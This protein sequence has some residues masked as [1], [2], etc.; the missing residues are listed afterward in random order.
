M[1]GMTVG[2]GGCWP[3]DFGP[4][5]PVVGEGVRA[6]GCRGGDGVGRVEGGGAGGAVG[7]AARGAAGG[8]HCMRAK[9]GGGGGWWGEL[10]V[11]GK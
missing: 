2:V 4:R 5:V 9:E 3:R 6:G 11:C 10:L 1:M 7:S 8:G